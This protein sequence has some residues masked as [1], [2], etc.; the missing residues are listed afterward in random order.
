MKKSH[1]NNFD[2]I[3]L[4]LAALVLL[5]HSGRALNRSSVSIDPL[6][7]VTL[8]QEDL[9]HVAVCGFFALSGCL[10]TA[11]WLNSD[12]ALSYFRKRILRIYPGFIVAWLVCAFV[13]LPLSGIAWSEYVA[14]IRPGLWAVKLALLRGFGGVTAF[15]DNPQQ[16]LNTS[17]WSIPVEFG[18]YILV[19]VLG[20][21][22][23]LR[24]R[25]AALAVTAVVG[26]V[27]AA[28]PLLDFVQPASGVLSP[29]RRP[30]ELLASHVTLPHFYFLL[31]MLAYLF[32]N[33]LRLS[34]PLA[35][36]ATLIL[37]VA[38]RVPPVLHVVTPFCWTYLLLYLAYLPRVP[39]PLIGP[40]LDLSY[41]LYLYGWP[42]QQFLVMWL[43]PSLNIWSLFALTVPLTAVAAYFSWT[44]VERP[45]Q[46][47]NRYFARTP[48]PAL[49]AQPEGQAVSNV[50]GL[51]KR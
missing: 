10:V 43:E 47:L 42:I 18:C 5:C 6:D 49:L 20:F 36:G 33:E 51:A 1:D 40:N 19:A 41:G 45:A 2:V 4:L 39:V 30:L 35:I 37:L 28:V 13:V 25:P 16:A 32:R 50:S 12:S 7:G 46:R 21:A 48:A 9:G 44:F 15:P 26:V 11:S 24:S 22:K 29:L 38:A 31:G 27:V 3:R 17:L 14:M 8:G 34:A 23:V